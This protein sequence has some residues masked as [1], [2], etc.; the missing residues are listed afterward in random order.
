ML[1]ILRTIL[2]GGVFLAIAIVLLALSPPRATSR[3]A[4]DG[5]VSARGALINRNDH[6]EW[7]QFLILAALRRADALKQLRNLHDTV[8]HHAPPPPAAPV[9]AEPDAQVTADAAVVPASTNEAPQADAKPRVKTNAKTKTDAKTVAETVVVATTAPVEAVPKAA[10]PET[11]ERETAAPTPLAD[12]PKRASAAPKVAD[13]TPLVAAGPAPAEP[14]PAAPAVASA[15]KPVAE[16]PTVAQMAP[17]IPP[18]EPT[19]IKTA[20]SQTTPADA[21]PITAAPAATAPAPTAA[22]PAHEMPVHV[23][24]IA[25]AAEPPPVPAPA[26]EKASP[27]DARETT[28]SRVR[29]DLPPP[30]APPAPAPEAAKVAALTTQRA[31]QDN[32]DITG[33]IDQPHRHGTTIPVGIGEASST[34]IEVLMPRERPPVLQEIDLRRANQSKLQPRRRAAHRSVRAKRKK[35]NKTPQPDNLFALLFAPWDGDHAFKPVKLNPYQP[36]QYRSGETVE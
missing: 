19:P 32:G 5:L 20:T 34:E 13:V 10:G 12:T 11:A 33:S 6:P 7:R 26:P 3:S 1:P 14:T 35:A 16:A 17:V 18:F 4:P 25:P 29:S 30:A 23:A 21:T 8:V 28:G 27:A 31:A 22:K 2:V 36:P 9:A 24:S 15:A